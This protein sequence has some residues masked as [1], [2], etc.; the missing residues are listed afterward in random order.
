MSATHNSRR[1]ALT[2]RL[3][4][5]VAALVLP[6][7]ARARI[8]RGSAVGVALVA[9]AE[10]SRS[11][12]FPLGLSMATCVR[13]VIAEWR[14][15]SRSDGAVRCG[16]HVLRRD[17]DARWLG[18]ARGL[19]LPGSIHGA[20]FEAELG[21][22]E[23]RLV[24]EPWDGRA[25]VEFLGQPV[26]EWPRPSLFQGSMEAASLM[27]IRCGSVQPLGKVRASDTWFDGSKRFPAGCA[28]FDSAMVIQDLVSLW[29]ERRD[30][31]LHSRPLAS[32]AADAAPA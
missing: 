29:R 28:E 5:A 11:R 13:G 18:P 16:L 19:S 8:V 6:A 15:G 27:G 20:R 3:D 14:E 1:V 10:R 17:V 30:A 7:S 21:T 24:V 22:D 12:R 23:V 4:P 26:P 9:P 2:Y 31:R 25:R 32:L